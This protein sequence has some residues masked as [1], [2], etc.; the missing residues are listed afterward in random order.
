MFTKRD[1]RIESHANC[2]FIVEW[3]PIGGANL[4]LDLLKDILNFLIRSIV[5]ELGALLCH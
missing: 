5:N 1:C 2:Q 4:A 3:E